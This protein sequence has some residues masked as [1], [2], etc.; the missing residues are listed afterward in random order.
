LAGINN[1]AEDCTVKK[2][3]ICHICDFQ[4]EYGGT[5]VDSLLSLNQYCRSQLKMETIC[6]FP[7]RASNRTWL[8]RFDEEKVQYGFV[9]RKK[10][11][12]S[13]VR[14]LL[15]GHDPLILH[16]HFF[17]FDLS[18]ILMKLML[19]RGAKVVWHYHSSPDLTLQQKVKDVI[20]LRLIFGFF[21]DR[22]IAVG[23]GI[24]RSLQNVGLRGDKAV[25]IQNAV[26]TRRFLPNSEV[27]GKARQSLGTPKGTVIYLLMGYAPL[28]K[29]VDI[30]MK[31]AAEIVV[32]NV[33]NVLFLIIGRD[34]TRKFVSQMPAA[35]KL[36]DAL[37][38]I[39]PVEDLSFLL[40]AV[41]VLVS[42]SRSEGLAYSVLEAMT[43]EKLVLSSDIASVRETYGRSEGVWLFPS[44]DWKM[45]A[46]LMAKVVLL[47][48]AERQSLG[49][50]NSQ[51]VIEN[52]SLDRW[53]EKVGQLYKE[54][55]GGRKQSL[56][57]DF[58]HGSR[59]SP[60]EVTSL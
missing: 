34:E 21:G 38:V 30:F 2:A 17:L 47:Q 37:I 4:P 51:Y 36:K 52:H 19:Y 57:E 1:E 20:K 27:R 28:I 33:S 26:N 7:E 49:R 44:E 15:K 48:S 45:L 10:S 59:R 29:G 50:A 22:C 41:D 39:D 14:L 56:T 60:R 35:A 46:D 42:A 12:L 24:Y 13:H 5:F 6:I 8:K 54:L 53:S 55:I 32:R 18:A 11:I 25:L 43:A 58:Q 16:T 40:N 31:A 3:V 9:P 23:D